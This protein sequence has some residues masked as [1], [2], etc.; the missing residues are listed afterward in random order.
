V[1]RAIKALKQELCLCTYGPE[2]SD[3]FSEEELKE[4]ALDKVEIEQTIKL[5]QNI[6]EGKAT[7]TYKREHA[8]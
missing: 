2:A 3:Y 4:L 8:P 6:E 7:I 5:L 1:K